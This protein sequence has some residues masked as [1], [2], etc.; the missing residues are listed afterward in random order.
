MYP[1]EQTPQGLCL[2]PNG[3]FYGASANGGLYGY[4]T[5]FELQP[6]SSPGGAWTETVLYSFASQNG[7][8]QEPATSP[9]MGPNGTIVG[10][11][12]AINSYGAVYQVQPPA[13]ARGHLD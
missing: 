13:R 1:D 9:V 6:P 11:T 12:A 7:D 2:R 4:G 3:T 10:T 8:G 5:V